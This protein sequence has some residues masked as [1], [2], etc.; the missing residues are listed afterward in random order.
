MKALHC[1]T[2][3]LPSIPVWR[4]PAQTAWQ[5]GV[6]IAAWWLADEAASALHLPFSGGVVGLF[7][8]VALLLSGWVR[9]TT[10]ELGAN[11]LLAN[12]LLFFIP[13]VVSVVQFTQ[14]LKSQGLMLF[15]NIG[16][17]FASVMLATALT[18]EWVCRYERKL[19]LNKLLRQRAARAAA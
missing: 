4:Q 9:P 19:R 16:L 15:V 17:G 3:A 7:V 2:A 10:I 11:W 5:V 13:L 14:L 12:M 18:V 1:S 8:L 6:L